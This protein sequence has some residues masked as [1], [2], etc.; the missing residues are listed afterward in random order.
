MA[1]FLSTPLLH[2]LNAIVLQDSAQMPSLA[3]G[4][5][6]PTCPQRVIYVLLKAGTTYALYCNLQSLLIDTKRLESKS[7]SDSPNVLRDA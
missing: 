2:C 3:A 5:P 7:T 4:T 1:S 6:S